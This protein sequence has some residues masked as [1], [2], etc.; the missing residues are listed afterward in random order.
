MKS[1]FGLNEPIPPNADLRERIRELTAFLK[2]READLAE[3]KAQLAK[4]SQRLD[5]RTD[6]LTRANEYLLAEIE[7]RKAGEEILQESEEK[8][9]NLVERSKAGICIVQDTTL[10]YINSR[11]AQI[12]GYSVK[13]MGETAFIAYVHPDSLFQ[14]EQ[15][16]ERFN[17]DK[18][19]DH[20]FETGLMHRNGNRLAVEFNI[21]MTHYR[22]QRAGLVM[23]YDISGR[24]RAEEHIHLL[25]QELLKAQETERQRIS[26]YLHDN[27][28]QDLS[29]AKIACETLFD[30]HPDIPSPLR[31]RMETMSNLLQQTITAVRGLA[32]DLRPPGLDQL[33][34]VRT[35]FLYCEDFSKTAGVD[36]DFFSA[37]M[38]DL[39]LDFDTEINLYRLIQEGLR[40]I[41]AHAQATRAAVRLVASSPHILLRI[42]DNGR[43]F[44]VAERRARS[45]QEKRMGLQSMEERVS[46]INGR[47][48]IQSRPGAGTSIFIE[49]PFRESRRGRNENDSHR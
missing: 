14:V 43:G 26:L 25:T 45:R 40:N 31:C 12:L 21:T 39:S 3:S 30:A 22:N 41:Q 18:E 1:G 47:M 38:E 10:K 4:L 7:E 42:K 13:E 23:V 15:C 8:Y 37:G 49:V 27:V 11:L 24:K 19:Y 17:V 20:H 36:V 35:V 32:Y 9:R 28:A 16:Y 46:L 44:D 48:R 34:L 33:G 5:Q 6:A 2:T 29:S